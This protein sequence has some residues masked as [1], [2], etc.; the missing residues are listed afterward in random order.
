[1]GSD[2]AETLHGFRSGCAIT[3]ALLG[4]EAL[5]ETIHHIGWTRRH[6]TQHR[7]RHRA[8][9]WKRRRWRFLTNCVVLL[10]FSR[11]KFADDNTTY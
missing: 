8:I 6:T 5:S 11:S 2:D 9:W 1:M 10:A 3:L 7:R 4:A